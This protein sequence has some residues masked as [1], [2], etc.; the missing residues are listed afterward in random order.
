MLREIKREGNALN[1]G[2]ATDGLMSLLSAERQQRGI[3]SAVSTG[4]VQK[5][6]WEIKKG[7]F[8]QTR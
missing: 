1:E 6:E 4:E 7:L 3:K 2:T 5:E 8:L